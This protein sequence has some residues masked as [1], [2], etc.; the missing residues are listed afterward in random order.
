MTKGTRNQITAYLPRP[1]LAVLYLVALGILILGA[2][3]ALSYGFGSYEGDVRFSQFGFVFGFLVAPFVALLIEIA[4]LLEPAIP[5]KLLFGLTTT[6][7]LVAAGV[8]G[9]YGFAMDPDT[10]DSNIT[11][12]GVGSLCF[13]PFI[14]LSLVVPIYSLVKLP[15]ALRESRQGYRDRT[16][17]DLIRANQGE[18]TYARL[19]EALHLSADEVDALLRRLVESGQIQGFRERAFGRFYTVPAFAERQLRLLGMVE[20]RGAVSLDEMARE[21]NVDRGLIK[22]WLYALVHRGEFTGYLNWDEEMIYSAQASQLRAGG[23]CPNC[24]GAM[25]LAGRGVIHCAHCG[26]EVFLAHPSEAQPS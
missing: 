12:L 26:T 15:G 8:A 20:S 16:A 24:G 11:G 17:L 19:G 10:A 5:A 2:L 23:Q 6:V 21:F 25:G 22:A 18:I 14:A 13:G 4:A 1:G 7:V 9:A 3:F